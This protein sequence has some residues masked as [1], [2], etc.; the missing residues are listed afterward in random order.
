MIPFQV[1]TYHPSPTHPRKTMPDPQIQ[2]R[3]DRLRLKESIA[4][5]NDPEAFLLEASEILREL[6]NSTKHAKLA[7]KDPFLK[8]LANRDIRYANA[9]AE[10][11]DTVNDESNH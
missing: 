7:E 9:I 2:S 6:G 10:M 3:L 11:I 5:F 4:Q 1:M 8:Q